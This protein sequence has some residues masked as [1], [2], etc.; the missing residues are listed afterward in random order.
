M[1]V[2]GEDEVL[3]AID[4]AGARVADGEEE[5]L[6]TKDYA[7]TADLHALASDL[8]G[9]RGTGRRRPLEVVRDSKGH[10]EASTLATS[11]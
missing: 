5:C 9:A 7:H 4:R 6:A 10:G 8:G 11:P 3:A 2:D 1:R